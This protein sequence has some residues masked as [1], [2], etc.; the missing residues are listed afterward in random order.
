MKISTRVRYGTRAMLDL[1]I[2][3][4]DGPVLVK[5]IAARQQIS[6]RYL[7]Q[8]LISL[9][10]AGLV[11]STRGTGGGF[12]LAKLPSQIKIIDIVQ[13]M[14]GSIAPVECV[15]A[16]ESYPRSAYCATR[17]V[18]ARVKDAVNNVLDSITLE[19]LMV[20]Q[21]DKEKIRNRAG[22]GGN[23]LPLKPCSEIDTTS[24]QQS[25]NTR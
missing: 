16:P 22:G 15:D 21:L 13:A 3:Y 24:R 23:A 5:E 2:H 4:Q 20:Q 12:A 17:D 6:A 14:D 7:E 8:L 10:V 19:H 11:H 25:K 1:A 18:W 9:K